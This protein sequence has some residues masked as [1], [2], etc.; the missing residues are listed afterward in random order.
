MW[1]W[2]VSVHLSRVWQLHTK[3][4]TNHEKPLWNGLICCLSDQVSAAVRVDPVGAVRNQYKSGAD[5]RRRQRAN[6]AVSTHSAPAVSH[7]N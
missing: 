3:I 5:R 4:A 7:V 2:S 1:R 6:Q